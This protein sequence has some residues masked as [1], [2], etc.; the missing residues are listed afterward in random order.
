VDIDDSVAYDSDA[1]PEL[2]DDEYVDITMLVVGHTHHQ[3]D[4]IARRY[5]HTSLYRFIGRGIEDTR[6]G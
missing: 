5:Y 4:I 2:E 6:G 3:A 1:M